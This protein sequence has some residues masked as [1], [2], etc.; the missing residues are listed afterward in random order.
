VKTAHAKDTVTILHSGGIDSTALIHFYNKLSF[1]IKCLYIDFGQKS[2]KQEIKSVRKIS[3]YYN[4][5][6]EILKVS[7][8]KKYSTGEVIGRNLFFLS[9]AMMHHGNNR[10]IIAI[11]VHSGT[12]YIDCSKSFIE[13]VN[14]IYTFYTNGKIVIGT[15]F[16]EFTKY[17]ILQYC[18]TEGVPLELTYS[19]ESGTSLPCGK[20]NTCKEIKNLYASKIK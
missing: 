17:D 14:K 13:A 10:G 18:L 19:C 11:G 1:A 15:P 4:L 7:G 9:T 8:S 2:A 3:K 16:I 6:N 5:N 20:C 12:Q